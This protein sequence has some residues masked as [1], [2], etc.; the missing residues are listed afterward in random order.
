MKNNHVP[1]KSK[2]EV[3]QLLPT[4][5][6]KYTLPKCIIEMG[7]PCN[8]QFKRKRFFKIKLN[9]SSTIHLTIGKNLSDVF[10]KTKLIY[11]LIPKQS[12]KPLFLID[13][14]EFDIMG[15]EFFEGLPIDEKYES[16]DISEDIIS[17]II[18]DLEKTLSSL[19]EKSTK[20]A[21]IQEF[22][23]FK[24]TILN[25]EAL[26]SLDKSF[27]KNYV[28]PLIE[29]SMLVESASLRWSPGDLAARNILIGDNLEYKI[30]DCEFAQK[31][32]FHEE[33]WLRLCTFSTVRFRGIPILNKKTKKYDPW[34]QIYFHLR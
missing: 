32:H 23:Q 21:L 11:D 33:D 34:I 5:Y 28:F 17:G 31:T 24:E 18:L 25:N 27:L 3:F 14:K 16:G 1:E 22:T 2:E 12:C 7:N 26:H 13:G 9:D 19:E 29:S 4:E 6:Q 30:I 10:E 15:Q 20:S 8:H